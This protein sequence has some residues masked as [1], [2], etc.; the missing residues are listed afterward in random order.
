MKRIVKP[1]VVVN[2]I[3]DPDKLA[4]AMLKAELIKKEQEDKNVETNK[5]MTFLAKLKIIISVI[6]NKNQTDGLLTAGFFGGLLSMIFNVMAILGGFVFL[7]GLVS[8]GVKIFTVSWAYNK[9][10]EN[11]CIILFSAI[12]LAATPIYALLFRA[13]A[14]E[15]AVEKDRNYIISVFSAVVSLAALVV[16]LVAL[17]KGVG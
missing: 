8:L 11:V 3:I 4:E 15:M 13:A 12:L 5:R 17:L 2:N 9:I 10:F 1:K 16:A 14:N 6:L 7:V